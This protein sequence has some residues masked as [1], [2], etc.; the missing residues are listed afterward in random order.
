MAK[1]CKHP[2][3]NPALCVPGPY[4]A[5]QGGAHHPMNNGG[6]W[7]PHRLPYHIIPARCP[8]QPSCN[9]LGESKRAHRPNA[10][11]QS[12]TTWSTNSHP[13]K[14]RALRRRSLWVKS[15]T[16]QDEQKQVKSSSRPIRSGQVKS[17]PRQAD[18]SRCMSLLIRASRAERYLNKQGRQGERYR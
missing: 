11:L 1:I 8:A 2:P 15:K 13:P 5:I 18:R 9:T 14:P 7:D 12:S 16:G 4:A 17:M 6:I 10:P 3:A